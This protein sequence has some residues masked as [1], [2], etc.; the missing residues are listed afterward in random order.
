METS[1]AKSVILNNSGDIESEFYSPLAVLDTDGKRYLSNWLE[2][3]QGI[4]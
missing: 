3:A 4:H 2:L 1:R